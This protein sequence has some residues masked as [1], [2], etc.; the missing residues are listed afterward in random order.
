MVKL[1]AMNK[2]L[3]LIPVALF[4]IGATAPQNNNVKQ[5]TIGTFSGENGT[6][7]YTSQHLAVIMT[8]FLNE[9]GTVYAASLN[10]NTT[11]GF[12]LEGTLRSKDDRYQLTRIALTTEDNRLLI[13]GKSNTYFCKSTVEGDCIL[14][15]EKQE[16]RTSYRPKSKSG[17]EVNVG[18]YHMRT[19][20]LP[21]TLVNYLKA[22]NIVDC[23]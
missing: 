6:L 3:L 4:F 22:L 14:T 17:K 11:E 8:Y 16:N 21:E 12:Y 18:I 7:C 13:T 20:Y 23:N 1:N 15:V 19:E 10:Y 2:Q 5:A 9:G